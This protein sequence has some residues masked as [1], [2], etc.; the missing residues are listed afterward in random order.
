MQNVIFFMLHSL[1]R[2]FFN[3]IFIPLSSL[4]V[5]SEFAASIPCCHLSHFRFHSGPGHRPTYVDVF[6]MHVE[7]LGIDLTLQVTEDFT[8]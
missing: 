6:L 3:H 7:Q 4:T 2:D 8:L 5:N 1:A